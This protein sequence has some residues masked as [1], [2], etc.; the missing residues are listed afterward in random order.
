MSGPIKVLAFDLD[1]TIFSEII[2]F[3]K[4][5]KNCAHKIMYKD[6]DVELFDVVYNSNSKDLFGDFLRKVNKY[7]TYNQ[8]I[9]FS[10]YKFGKLELK[11]KRSRLLMLSKCRDRFKTCLLTNGVLQAQKNKIKSLGIED[12]FDSIMYA[13]S[14]GIENEKPN[15]KAFKMICNHFKCKPSEVMFVGD[16]PINDILGAKKFGMTAVWT[17]EFTECKNIPPEADYH[18]QNLH[19]ITKILGVM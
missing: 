19:E 12:L 7:S 1:N 16:H 6:D 3:K 17:S 14:N 10:E 9:L 18:I 2:F 11:I 15:S 8:N 5:I 13:R 4:I